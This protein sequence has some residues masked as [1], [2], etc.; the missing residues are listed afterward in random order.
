MHCLV[1]CDICCCFRSH[2]RVQRTTTTDTTFTCVMAKESGGERAMQLCTV[3]HARVFG[4]TRLIQVGDGCKDWDADTK[5]DQHIPRRERLGYG[6]R[7]VSYCTLPKEMME[8][9]P[10]KDGFNKTKDA[11]KQYKQKFKR[12]VKNYTDKFATR[13]PNKRKRTTE[14]TCLLSHAYMH[15]TVDSLAPDNPRWITWS[16]RA[17]LVQSLPSTIPQVAASAQRAR[18]PRRAMMMTTLKM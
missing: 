14:V 12:V 1:R 9:R 18:K 11:Y 4:V 2:K 17:M 3:H 5:H 15:H 13:D 6:V 7:L 8:T 10:T 16:P